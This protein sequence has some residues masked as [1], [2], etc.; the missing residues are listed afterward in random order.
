[1]SNLNGQLLAAAIK[2][3]KAFNQDLED[4]AHVLLYPDARVITNIPGTDTPFTVQMYKEAIG[5][6]YQRITLYICTLEAVEN[7]C[8]TGTTSSSD[9][10]S[11]VFAKLPSGDSLAD[12]VVSLDLS[13]HLFL[14]KVNLFYFSQSFVCCMQVWDFPN[15]QST[16]RMDNSLP[17]PLRHPQPASDRDGEPTP[18]QEEVQSAPGQNTFYSNYTTV[19]ALIIIDSQSEPEEETEQTAEE[20]TEYLTAPDIVAELSAKI[21]N[22]SCS[23]FNI[24]RANVWDGAIRGFKGASFDPSHQMQVKFT[25]DEGQTE[26]GVDTGGPKREFLTLLMECLRMRRIFDGPQDRKFLKFDNAAA[27]DD[28][29]FHA[30]RMIATSI[31][32]KH[33]EKKKK[34]SCHGSLSQN[35]IL[36][37]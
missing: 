29:Y 16:P 27:K 4:G 17:G 24:N 18:F 10:D 30:G 31:V 23:R 22:T 20:I 8:Y 7:S 37:V 36:N 32:Q 11:V 5:K 19:Y 26:D 25:D 12:T 21:K 13:W 9:E 3:Q 33:K 14:I 28:E 15:E 35:L 34:T 1:M 6:P 2:K